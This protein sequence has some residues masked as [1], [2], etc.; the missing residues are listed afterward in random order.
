MWESSDIYILCVMHFPQCYF[1]FS[2]LKEIILDGGF[3]SVS[4]TAYSLM[5]Q[6]HDHKLTDTWGFI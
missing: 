3:L 2:P 5:F 1:I 6:S 4:P